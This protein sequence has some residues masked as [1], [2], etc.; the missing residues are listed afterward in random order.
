MKKYDILISAVSWEDR[1]Y[2]SM[3]YDLSQETIDEVLLFNTIE[4]KDKTQDNFRKVADL[5][6][7]QLMGSPVDIQAFDDVFTWKTIEKLFLNNSITNKT[8]LLDISTM[9]RYL[10]WFLLHFLILHDNTVCY[11][12]FSPEKYEECE[13]LT[14]EPAEPRLIL[15]HSGVYLP[16]RNSVLIVQSGFDVERVSLL[17]R[18]YE[19]EKIILCVQEGSQL[20]NLTKNIGCHERYL[21]DQ[22][23]EYISINAFSGDYGYSV[24]EKLVCSYNKKNVILASFGPKLLAVQMFKITINYPEVGLVDVPVHIYNEKYSSGIDISNI[25]N[26]TL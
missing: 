13:W 16:N 20:G 14:D 9:P 8:V 18:T 2:K 7:T 19:P 6:F 1:F 10:I 5:S 22:E 25:Y 24:L 4:F 12:Y 21:N 11:R 23:I 15:K 17:I 3:E 26:G